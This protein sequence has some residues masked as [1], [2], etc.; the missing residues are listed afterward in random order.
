METIEEFVQHYKKEY[1]FYEMVSK[2]VAQ[3]MESSLHEAGIRAIVTYRAKKNPERLLA[4]LYQ[5]NEER[6]S[7]YS[8]LDDI[9]SDICDLSGVRVALYFPKDRDKVG[10]IIK[11]NFTLLEEPKIFPKKKKHRIIINDF[12]VIGQDITEF[13]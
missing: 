1:D 5:R 10:D 13:N 12:L 2:L 11:E 6:D 4:K 8:S 3:Q 7:K 9:Y